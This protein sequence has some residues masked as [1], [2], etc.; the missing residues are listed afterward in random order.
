[1][2]APSGSVLTVIANHDRSGRSSVEYELP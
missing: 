2:R 1:V